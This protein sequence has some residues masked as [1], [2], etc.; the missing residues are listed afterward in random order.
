M[1]WI[2]FFAFNGMGLGHI[3][4]L[5]RLCRRM[6]EQDTT[7]GLRPLFVTNSLNHQWLQKEG[8]PYCYVSSAIED[9]FTFPVLEKDFAPSVAR[10]FPPEGLSTAILERVI[11]HVQPAIVVVDTYFFPG[12]P[13]YCKTRD[14]GFMGIFDSD[15]CETL[16]AEVIAD[17]FAHDGR[18]LIANAPHREGPLAR[19]FF[20]CGPFLSRRNPTREKK[21]ETLYWKK[22]GA[23]RIVCAQGG[24][25]F[26]RANSS[27]EAQ[28]QIS[29]PAA[30]DD[31]IGALQAT[32]EIEALFFTGPY[33]KKEEYP[34]WHPKN[35][36]VYDFEPNLES[37]FA[38]ADLALIRGGYSQ[39]CE[40]VGMSCP[41]ILYPRREATDDQ[42]QNLV[43]GAGHPAIL[44]WEGPVQES[45][46]TLRRW[47]Q[48]EHLT[49][50]RSSLA[51]QPKPDGLQR[52]AVFV[53][54][55][56]HRVVHSISR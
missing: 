26:S 10:R 30:I 44:C 51:E 33:Y 56:I 47:I 9:S 42:R 48:R 15:W 25:G 19:R 55:E 50:M 36:A 12:L 14:I 52:A 1:T 17:I 22:P 20:Y 31:M 16:H 18:V 37:L 27:F 7:G 11:D 45:L 2:C 53:L 46:S 6:L 43:I 41:A 38:S 8:W 4:R 40:V 28:Q 35:V 49:Q 13:Q 21:L 3:Q 54:E 5:V 32:V 29:F 24:G 23:I 34:E 39:V